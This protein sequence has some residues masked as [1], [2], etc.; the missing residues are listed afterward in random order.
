MSH[1]NSH[2]TGVAGSG[3]VS[4]RR[5]KITPFGL[6]LFPLLF[7]VGLSVWFYLFNPFRVRWLE[8]PQ[9]ELTV[10]KIPPSENHVL[11]LFRKTTVSSTIDPCRVE[12]DNLKLLIKQTRDKN[13]KYGQLVPMNWDSQTTQILNRLIE[14][15]E[16][17]KLRRIPARYDKE[18][19]EV[20]WGINNT[21]RATQEF[22]AY[23]SAGSGETLIREAAYKECKNHR[24]KAI[25]KFK[26]GREFFGGG[27]RS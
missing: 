13:G 23:C 2:P 10:V 18:Y 7:L 12:L 16:Q 25:S 5:P 8:D 9:I 6:V 11:H 3:P 20:L 4:S 22:R 15:M 19:R 27:R 17:A 14:I 21:Y 24:K 26:E 1:S